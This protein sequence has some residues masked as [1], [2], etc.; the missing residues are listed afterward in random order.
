MARIHVYEPHHTPAQ[1]AVCN[2]CA[3]C[4]AN[5]HGHDSPRGAERRAA[6]GELLKLDRYHYVKIERT[7]PELPSG[8]PEA[9]WYPQLYRKQLL[10]S[11][12]GDVAESIEGKPHLAQPFGQIAMLVMLLRSEKYAFALDIA[13]YP[14]AEDL[15]RADLL[16]KF[17]LEPPLTRE[18]LEP[19]FAEAL[20][21]FEA[22]FP[23]ARH[24]VM[25]H[26]NKVIADLDFK[27]LEGL[28]DRLPRRKARARIQRLRKD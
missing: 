19:M 8:R 9:R 6:A 11:I 21:T 2:H 5:K 3:R 12:L 22:E 16:Q 7:Q 26:L 27:M 17:G 15:R 20:S 28:G 4:A 13:D 10:R 23:D 18:K 1:Q 14:E 25:V 24:P